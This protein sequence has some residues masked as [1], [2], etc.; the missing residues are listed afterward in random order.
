M[1]VECFSVYK[2]IFVLGL[3]QET[4][5]MEKQSIIIF[6]LI[7]KSMSQPLVLAASKRFWQTIK[8]LLYILK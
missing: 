6:F 7:L 4:V 2:H 5:G 3:L 1:R 8:Q